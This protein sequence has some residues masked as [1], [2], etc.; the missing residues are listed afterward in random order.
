MLVRILVVV[1]LLV[2]AC[3]T[4]IAQVIPEPQPI[5]HEEP[6]PAPVVMESVPKSV[7]LGGSQ[8]VP[9]FMLVG[10]VDGDSVRTLTDSMS[11]VI[12]QQPDAI[13]IDIDSPGGDQDAAFALTKLFDAYPAKIVCVVDGQ[14]SSAAFYILQACSARVMTDRS[15]LM[16]HEPYYEVHEADLTRDYLERAIKDHER[17][18]FAWT[19]FAG[20]RLKIPMKEFRAKIRFDDWTMTAPEALKVGAV[21]SVISNSDDAWKGLVDYLATQKK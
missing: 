9:R 19:A 7:T 15:T 14:A 12:S 3:C 1:A 10:I 21:D 2:S 16:A 11:N 20:R 6:V 5:A 8:Q 17:I 13:V 18:A 4:D